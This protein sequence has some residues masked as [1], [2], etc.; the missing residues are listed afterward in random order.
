MPMRSLFPQASS[1]FVLLAM[2]SIVA[3]NGAIHSKPR[4]SLRTHGNGK[5]TRP[6]F[7][8][9]PLRALDLDNGMQPKSTNTDPRIPNVVH[10]VLTDRGTRFFDWTCYL[11]IQVRIVAV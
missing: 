8:R 6:L 9:I 2:L 1:Q 11:A 3:N 5:V 7:G 4:A 10:F